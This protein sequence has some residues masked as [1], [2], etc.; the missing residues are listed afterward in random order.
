M[1]ERLIHQIEGKKRQLKKEKEQLDAADYSTLVNNNL[2]LIAPGSPGGPHTNRKTRN[3]RR[4]DYEDPA[5]GEP[6]NKR[7]R[8]MLGDGDIGSPNP[9]GSRT[10]QELSGSA[11][12]E[13]ITSSTSSTVDTEVRVE[14]YFSSRELQNQ[15]KL[16]KES[17]ARRW[18]EKQADAPIYAVGLVN[19]NANHDGEDGDGMEGDLNPLLVAPAMDR[20]GSSHATRST[21][22]LQTAAAE[23]LLHHDP[24]LAASVA[25]KGLDDKDAQQMYGQAVLEAVALRSNLKET[26]KDLEALPTSGFSMQEQLEDW[27]YLCTL[28]T[29]R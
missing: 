20:T 18:A 26:N 7:K 5:P 15:H 29:D 24:S 17:V 28:D 9:A 4:N 3:T 10:R 27:A 11:L 21:R 23:N 6:T 14:N 1:R 22:A 13:K 8:K 12:W 25:K 19:G 2:T 16:A